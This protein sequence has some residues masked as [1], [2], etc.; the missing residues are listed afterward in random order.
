[1]KYGLVYISETTG[2][3]LTASSDTYEN[4]DDTIDLKN[5]QQKLYPKRQYI[6]VPIPSVWKTEDTT[7]CPVCEQTLK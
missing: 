4:E 7:D 6:V 1:M 2:S 3:I 5:A